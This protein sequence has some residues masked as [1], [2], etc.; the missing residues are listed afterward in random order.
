MVTLGALFLVFS[1][2]MIGKNQNILGSS[3]VITAMT[4]N[5]NGLVPGN[6]VRFKGMNVGTVKSIEMHND[7]LINIDLYISRR[8]QQFIRKNAQVSI[9][10]D[11][12]MGNKVIH[13][14]P[15]DEYAEVIEPGDVIYSSSKPNMNEM[16]GRLESTSDYFEKTVINLYDITSR[17][18]KSEELW[19]LL[20]DSIMMDEIRLTVSELRK[21][22]TEA[23]EMVKT[24][25]NLISALEEGEGMIPSLFTDTTMMQNFSATLNKIQESSNNAAEI[26]KAVKNLIRELEG[27]QGTAGMVLRDTL[28]QESLF[29]TM[30][31][32]EESSEKL[33]VNLEAMRSSFLFRRYFRRLEREQRKEERQNQN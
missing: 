16:M 17:I 15:Q 20:S 30:M 3:V 19:S 6:N 26:S 29:N 33:N 14:I 28:L 11:G 7:S 21:T 32:L 1:L 8:M 2:Y 13:I 18:N 27:G 31:H 25:N 23:R 10:T 4:D 24:A 22:G 12:L 9:G 5:T